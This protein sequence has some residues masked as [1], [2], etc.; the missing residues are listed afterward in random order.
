LAFGTL[1]IGGRELLAGGY[2]GKWLSEALA[3]YLNKTGSIILILTLLFLAIIL[4]TQ[5]SFGRLFG[6]LAQ[7]TYDQWRATLGAIRARREERR[8]SKSARRC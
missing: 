8:R 3:E 5:F 7:M 6:A 4:S 2:A 1:R